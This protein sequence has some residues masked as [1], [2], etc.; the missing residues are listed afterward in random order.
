MGGL[1]NR[2]SGLSSENSKLNGKNETLNSKLQKSNNS[3]QL[4]LTEKE[5]IGSKNKEIEKKI[6]KL[7]RG[8]ASV[9]NRMRSHIGDIIA[10]KLKGA[11]LNIKVD[12][13]TGSIILLMGDG[14]LF[15]RNSAVL[16]RKAKHAL[17]KIIP[18][19]ADALF[20]E[21]WIEKNIQEIQIVGHSSPTYKQNYVDPKDRFTQAFSYNL[22]LSTRRSLEI[23]KFIF[24]NDFEEFPYSLDFRQKVGAT[25]KGY[26][27]PIQKARGVASVDQSSDEYD[28]GIYDC[29][30]SRRVEIKFLLKDNEK[31]YKNLINLQKD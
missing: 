29:K 20:K 26:S 9:K 14:L 30:Q 28:C 4:C 17:R 15:K 2:A 16:N 3:Y 1:K 11:D 31:A 10:G 23:V 5:N 18:I 7:G 13:K 8:I 27:V 24:S 6:G 25:G 21:R 12:R 19:Y 22:D